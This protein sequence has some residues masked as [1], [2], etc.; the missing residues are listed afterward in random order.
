MMDIGIMGMAM[1]HRSMDVFV[2]VWPAGIG[3]GWVFV[4]MMLIVLV[5]VVVLQG[6]VLVFVTM[7]LRQVQVQ[8]DG[9]QCCR[10]NKW[11]GERLAEEH[12]RK[13][14]ADEGRR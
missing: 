14:C 11:P 6:G 12:D 5:P 10:R 1:S 3:S 13:R 8:T 4:L 9:H 7:F 2:G